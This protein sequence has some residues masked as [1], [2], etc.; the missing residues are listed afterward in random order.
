MRIALFSDN[1]YPEL[2]GISSSIIQTSKELA[3]RGHII[4]FYAPRHPKKSYDVIKMPFEEIRLGDRISIERFASLPF[5]AGTGQGRI[6]VPTGF[7]SFS[8]KK[9]RPDI[10]HAHLIF[11][12][13][14]EAVIAS[15]VIGAPLIGTNHTPIT[16]FVRYGPIKTEWFKKLALKYNS[17]F[18]NKCE[19]VS[20]P[21]QA[22]LTEM[23]TYGFHAPHKVV[24]NP[25]DL[26][27]FKPEPKRKKELKEKYGFSGFTILYAGRLAEEKRIDLILQAAAEA[28][29]ELPDITVSLC[30]KGAAEES[31]RKMAKDLG[32]EKAIIFTG[33]LETNKELAEVYNASDVFSIMSPAESQSLVAMQGLATGLPV[34]SA[35]AWGLAEYLSRA[36]GILVEPGDWRALTKQFIKLHNDANLRKEL[37]AQGEKFVQQFSAPEIAGQWEKIYEET[38][39]K[40]NLKK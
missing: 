22:V 7:R 3:K 33:F 30:G 2:S 40:Y 15:R 9:F 31:L 18:Y 11:G 25:L 35:R 36:G 37:G 24:S 10:L 1:F 26:D 34:V 17:W 29:K 16:E 23:E 38:I 12:T 6:V 39:R 5:A 8:I 19:F 27:T 14:L 20:S 4:R 28:K 13:G 21:A 32:I